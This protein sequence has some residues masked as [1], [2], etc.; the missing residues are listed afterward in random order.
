MSLVHGT[1]ATTA[2][3]MGPITA[4]P[5]KRLLAAI[6]GGVTLFVGAVAA[7]SYVL[8]ERIEVDAVARSEERAVRFVRAAEAS[9]NRA[10][11]GI[12]LVLA[13]MQ[14][15]LEPAARDDGTF[16]PEVARRQMQGVVNR[17]LLLRDLAV[18][19]GSGTVLASAR[20]ET[21]RLGLPLP[22]GFLEQVQAQSAPQL[23]ISA[24][25]R[26]PVMAEWTIYFA[27]SMKLP[28]DGRAIAVAEVPMALLATLLAQAVEVP[29][30]VV[31]LE[32]EDGQLLVSMPPSEQRTGQH[33]GAPLAADALA[34]LPRRAPG[35]LY[36]Q[37][38]IV[39]ARP[40]LYRS[41]VIA[42]SVRLDA[43]LAEWRRDRTLIYGVAAAFAAMLV[44]AAAI[45]QAQMTRLARA[46]FDMAQAK[47]TLD[48]ALASM[49]DGFLLCDAHDRAV[50]WNERYLEM[51]PWLRDTLAV[52]VPFE[53]LAQVASHSLY[54]ASEDEPRRAAWRE[55]RLAMHRSGFGTYEQE[56]GDGRVIH[57]VERRTLDGGVV[58][59]FR[60]VTAAERELRRAK[61][62]AEAANLAKS[63][64]L[65]SMS[66]EI[67]TPLN[68]V[69][70]IND[71]LLKT[72][73]TE[74]QREYARTIRASGRG[75]LAIINDIL[76]LSKIEAGRMELEL[77]D[78][79]PMRVT[80][81]VIASVQ[82]RAREKGL[83][84]KTVYAPDLPVALLGDAGRLRQVLFNL[85][86][87]AVKFTKQGGVGVEMTQRPLGA[88]RIELQ[89]AVRD[90]GIGI[91]PEV[92]PKLFERF[93]QADSG[94][95]RKFG[96]SGLGLA[97][98]RDIIQLMGGR[99]AVE[100]SLGIGSIFR[101][102]V[103]LALGNTE[104]AAVTDT[105]FDA[106]VDMGTSLRI[107]VAEDNAVNQLLI[108]TLLKQLGHDVDLV[109]NGREAVQQVQAV[110]YD[111]VLM[112][113]QMPEMDGTSA[114]R[115]IR[116]LR[117]KVSRIPIVALT[118]NAMVEDRQ[119]YLAAGMNDYLSK[120]IQAKQ[121]SAVLERMAHQ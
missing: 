69:L 1:S 96:G 61:A 64:F 90:S 100:T 88:E 48:R 95:A 83:S 66:H 74:Q 101:V 22:P 58:G 11:I 80:D 118:A 112:D 45:L 71:L 15:V 111:L 108:S 70:G 56:L 10:L 114:T 33:V 25:V 86:G 42:A 115:E 5:R 116:A 29:G 51:Y 31:T 77:T 94:T 117:S 93:T 23:A 16:D 21:G 67:R 81:E 20:S 104:R 49:A 105:Q 85:I 60:D 18:L 4:V 87:N 9:I 82:T 103:P 119:A 7:A 43:A 89:I 109:E 102:F 68:G 63:Q 13:D 98:S 55:M 57:V 41:V 35:R 44:A 27:R 28:G 39:V 113:I 36:G 37:P 97:I 3:G 62:A 50:A 110:P 52:G 59:V 12:D 34:G 76:D 38:A 65:A 17:G 91:A 106:P 73:L 2:A 78:F 84:L 99:I 72:S 32:R 79:D 54:P 75:L 24:P 6:W 53:R 19:D 8:V 120:P 107:L 92:L 14:P 26:N 121:L 46:R 40:T 47:D 30:L